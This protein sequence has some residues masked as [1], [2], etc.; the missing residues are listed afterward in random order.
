VSWSNNDNPTLNDPHTSDGTG[1]GSFT[2]C[3]TGL[4]PDTSYFVRAYAS[5]SGGTAYGY[6]IRLQTLPEFSPIVFNPHLTY[7]SVS[8]IDLNI[9]KTIKIGTQTW[10][11]ENL[12]TT[13]YNDGTPIPDV[14]VDSIWYQLST[15][16]YCWLFNNEN[17]FKDMYGA[18]YNYYAVETGKICPTGWHVSSVVEW[19]TLVS[20]LGGREIAGGKL[21]ES[22][23]THWKAPNTA[24][25]NISGF[26]ALP[27]GYRYFSSFS[28]PEY[29]GRWWCSD[30]W[31][32][33]ELQYN[34]SIL[35]GA[36]CNSTCGY[37][38][39]CVKD[40]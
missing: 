28:G 27:G 14:T 22:G 12:K 7:D 4:R 9:Y 21:K 37:S 25:D 24:A 36:S 20:Y 15:P 40:N 8:D 33:K 11:A 23:I 18:I 6:E 3:L 38:V 2:S 34:T 30:L 31:G 39:R 10:M 16:A 5:N 19:D 17:I 1:I 26:T 32:M 13:K 29:R 35:D